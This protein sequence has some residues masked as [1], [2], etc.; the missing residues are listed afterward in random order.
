MEK[1]FTVEELAVRWQVTGR[2][3]RNWVEEGAFPNAY[4]IGPGRKSP[5]RIP[6]SD[7]EEFE[8]NRKVRPDK[9]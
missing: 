8:R 2:T 9:N 5:I 6:A 1:Q 4:R 7:V 3:V